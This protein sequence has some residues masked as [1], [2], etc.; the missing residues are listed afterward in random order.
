[1]AC[2]PKILH[3]FAMECTEWKIKTQDQSEKAHTKKLRSRPQK[4]AGPLAQGVI[5]PVSWCGCVL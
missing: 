4:L 5:D 3:V 2:P 1:M